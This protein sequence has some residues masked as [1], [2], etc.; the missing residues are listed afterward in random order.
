MKEISSKAIGKIV[1]ENLETASVF[2]AYKLDFCCHGDQS[3][4]EACEIN[5]LPLE[6]LQTELLAAIEKA[7]DKSTDSAVSA[8]DLP[9][10]EL[11][12]YILD[13]HHGFTKDT[14]AFVETLLNTVVRVHSDN[15]PELLTVQKD[16]AGL[17]AELKQHLELEEDE[18]FPLFEKVFAASKERELSSEERQ[19]VGKAVS[20]MLSEHEVAGAVLDNM[21]DYTDGFAIPEDACNSFTLLYKNLLD[22]ERD[23]HKHIALENYLLYP[24]MQ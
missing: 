3:L 7:A 20:L 15:H 1:A 24:K 16:F 12:K 10:D 9:I 8:K 13:Q 17:S 23:L 6:K 18:H 11:V 19:E 5:S 22:L 21:H 4:T 2:E 14:I